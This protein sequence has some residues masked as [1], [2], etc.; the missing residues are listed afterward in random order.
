[1]TQQR[2]GVGVIGVGY[3]GPKIVRT[4]TEMDDA[5]ILMASDL[6]ECRLAALK[7]R[8]PSL[9]TT[10]NYRELLDHPKIEAVI[11]AT[12]IRTHHRLAMDALLAGKHVLVEKPLAASVEE[13]EELNETA[14]LVD[15]QLMVGH[16]FQYN[17]AVQKLR[18]LIRS[19]EL[20][21][22]FYID[23]ARL[24]LG[25]FQRDINVVWDLAPHDISILLHILRDEPASV[26]A[27]GAAHVLEDI[28]DMAHIELDFPDGVKAHIR[29]SWLD[30][31]KVRRVTVVGSNKMAVFDDTAEEKLRIYDKRVSLRAA[32]GMGGPSFEYHD[33]EVEVP[34]LEQVEPLRIQIGHFV[35]C[36]RTGRRPISDG[37][38]GLEVVRILEAADESRRQD[39]RRIW[40]EPSRRHHLTVLPPV[41]MRRVV[42]WRAN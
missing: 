27:R 15:R 25:L 26:C 5:E 22:I 40:L 12:P 29:V 37:R 8:H 2:I 31:G 39:S 30:P 3:W 42:A 34:Y 20:G 7:E 19:G 21:K 10:T 23:S 24:N 16:T 11:V 35:K 28:D 6:A 17:P 13:A 1:M 36:A 18:E 41:P 14:Q 4:L 33:G 9:H 32:D 38:I